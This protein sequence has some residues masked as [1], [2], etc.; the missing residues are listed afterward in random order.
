MLISV[1]Y[2]CTVFWYLKLLT[3]LCNLLDQEFLVIALL[4]VK[5][6]ALVV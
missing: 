6:P 2:S 5:D 1:L 4:Q 3:Q